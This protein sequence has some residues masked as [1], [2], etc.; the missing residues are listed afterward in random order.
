MKIQNAC[1]Y[2]M[3]LPQLNADKPTKYLEQSLPISLII[4]L[5]SAPRL[6]HLVNLLILSNIKKRHNLV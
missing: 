5:R 2:N 1:L 3:T 4:I 6:N